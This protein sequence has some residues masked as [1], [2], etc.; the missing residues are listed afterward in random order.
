MPV[1]FIIIYRIKIELDFETEQLMRIM[2]IAGLNNT[3]QI[4]PKKNL[5]LLLK[6]S[7]GNL[8]KIKIYLKNKAQIDEDEIKDME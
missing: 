2:K 1:F 8:G 7:V 3:L 5:P 6:S 4:Y